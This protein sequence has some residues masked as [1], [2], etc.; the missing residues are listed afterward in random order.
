MDKNYKPVY[1]RGTKTGKGVI[2][3]LEALGG[4]NTRFYRGTDYGSIYFMMPNNFI[5]RTPIN[6][7]YSNYVIATA[8]EV[9]PLRWRAENKGQYYVISATMEVIQLCDY[10]DVQCT[11]LYKCGNYFK[12]EVE[13]KEMA[14][15]IKKILLPD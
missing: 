10:R 13:A 9:K 11:N 1:V 6:S 2:E 8:K 5:C 15:K 4:K 7:A 3:A 14:K 12:T